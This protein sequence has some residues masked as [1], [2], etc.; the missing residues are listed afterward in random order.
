VSI[1]RSVRRFAKI[2]AVVGA[3]A[4]ACGI[5]APFMPLVTTG[6][7]LVCASGWNL[8]RPSVEG[9]IVDGA[10]VI[11]TGVFNGLAWMWIG[12]AHSSSAGK[13]VFTGVVQIVWGVRRLTTYASA[14]FAPNDAPAIARLEAIVQELA[15]RR[16]KDDPSVAEF[17]TGR[18]HRQ[19]NRLGLYPE[20]AI[21]LFGGEAVRLEK[22][23][24][25]WIE[26]RGTTSGS[27]SLKVKIQMSDLELVGRMP[28]EHFERFERW[29][30]GMSLP[31][32][33]AA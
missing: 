1:K 26:A 3:V 14:R 31:Q 20:G 15:K 23:G 25:I 29:K 28:V 30:L 16:A 11:L 8:W 18:F 24:D 27:R 22:R 4:L 19:R 17:W 13:W 10:A 21:A 9:L 2:A 33:I 12:D 6:L 32:P 5:A 7:A